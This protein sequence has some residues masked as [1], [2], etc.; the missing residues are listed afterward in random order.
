MDEQELIAAAHAGN[1]EA[2]LLCALL[3]K[4]G[5][6]CPVDA[7]TAD[8]WFRSAAESG[9]P[10]AQYVLAEKLWESDRLADRENAL[11]YLERAATQGFL[12]AQFRMG[13]V[14]EQGIGTQ[15]DIEGAVEWYERASANGH[16]EAAERLG[17][18]F[19]NGVGV[20]ADLG[21]AIERYVVAAERGRPSAALTLALLYHE[22][23]RIPPNES[24]AFGWYVKAAALG[25]SLACGHL[26]LV[27]E[28]GL[29]GRERNA[30]KAKEYAEKMI[31]NRE[32]ERRARARA[33][34]A[35]AA[36]V[37]RQTD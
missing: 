20:T 22:G 10:L 3:A 12:V 36:S 33:R 35:I 32:S 23:K 9:L 11:S 4:W 17:E 18:L 6:G 5:Y 25:S 14:L 29:L 2:Q 31:M 16:A 37:A 15:R 30:K 24:E 28:K 8:G 34:A 27:Y 19:E 21:L 26:A 7:Q 13:L 1:P